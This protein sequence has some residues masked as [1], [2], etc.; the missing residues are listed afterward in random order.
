MKVPEPKKLPSGNWRV[1]LTLGG[2]RISIT[3]KTKEECKAEA[4]LIKAE[5]LAGKRNLQYR[6]AGE[7]TL[8]E[9]V[10]NYLTAN[11]FVMS[12]S[13]LRSA[14]SH[15]RNRFKPYQNKCLKDIDF[16][17]MI[18]EELE[19][20]S[21]KTVENGWGIVTPAMRAVGFPVPEVNLAEVPVNEIPFLKPDEV[22]KFCA[23]VKGRNYEIPAL[24]MLNGLRL[25]ELQAL[26]W[27]NVDLD[28][29]LMTV[30]GATVRGPEG[31]VTKQA[32][33][34]RTSTRVVPILIPQLQDAL[35]AVPVKEGLV[36]EHGQQTL[37][38]DV[39]RA[40]NR[41]GVTVVTNH[42]LRHSF[43][44]YLYWL[45][46]NGVPGLSERQMMKWGG[47]SNIQTM[48]KIYIKIAESA[49]NDTVNAVRD[50]FKT[51][52]KTATKSKKPRK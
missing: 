36:D 39:K 49:E 13:T 40:C 11:R 14:K 28:R 1:R 24:I 4:R 26:E 47:W 3:R 5:Y 37:L 50:F 17:K 10:E 35:E 31:K 34:N 6:K 18:N 46:A 45:S 51:D 12:P 16:Q 20:K 7:L 32:N 29:K 25:S 21:P 30:K 15:A 9:I 23:A 8:S 52:T 43:I 41:A 42:G 27:K 19:H 44:S 22:L 48:H 2:E 38:D 33:K